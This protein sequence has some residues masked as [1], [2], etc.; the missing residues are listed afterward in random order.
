M[1]KKLLEEFDDIFLDPDRLPPFRSDHN[2]KI[3]LIL[4]AN[5]VNKRLYRY[6]KSYIQ[7]Y[8]KIVV[9]QN[10]NSPYGSLI[11]LVGKTD[12]TWKL[13]VEYR[14]LHKYTVNKFHI[15]LV[16][17][18]LDKLQGSSTYKKYI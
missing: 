9:I 6:A 7:D 8:L 1:I 2:H 5:L 17:D 15:P 3:P 14:D 16:D 4:G 10:N 11:V 13:C 12:G 18:L